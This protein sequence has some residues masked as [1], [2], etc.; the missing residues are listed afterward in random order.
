M[1]DNFHYARNI[2]LPGS[3]NDLYNVQ[4]N[5]TSPSESDL[6]LHYDWTEEYGKNLLNDYTFDYKRV[7]FKQIAE[8][9]RN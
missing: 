6:A 3:I 2:S 8:A 7:N 4:F 9:I 5:I 1:I